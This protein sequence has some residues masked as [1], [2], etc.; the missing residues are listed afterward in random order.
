MKTN[1][2]Q[3]VDKHI[4][5]EKVFCAVDIGN[6]SGDDYVCMSNPVSEGTL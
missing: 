2:T 5:K 6:E 4:G 3:R 1:Q